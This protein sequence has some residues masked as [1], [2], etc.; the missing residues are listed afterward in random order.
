MK[1]EDLSADTATPEPSSYLSKHVALLE[2][3]PDF[4]RLPRLHQASPSASLDKSRTFYGVIRI[5][6]IVIDV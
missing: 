2:L 4:Y 5:F 1:E 3:A 6:S